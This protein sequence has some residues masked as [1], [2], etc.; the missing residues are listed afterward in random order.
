MSRGCKLMLVTIDISMKVMGSWQRERQLH[1]YGNQLNIFST[2]F[3]CGIIVGAGLHNLAQPSPT[4]TDYWQI[5]NSSSNP[6]IDSHPP[7]HP[8][9]NMWTLLV[10]F[11]HG[12]C[13]CQRLSNYIRPTILYRILWSDCISWFCFSTCCMVYS[14]WAREEDGDIRSVAECCGH[15]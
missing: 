12:H 9:A 8:H 7:I 10:H 1:L 15:V 11:S 4:R 3:N 6:L 14:R 2:M 5:S 13:R